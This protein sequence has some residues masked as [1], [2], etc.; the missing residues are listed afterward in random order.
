MHQDK[1]IELMQFV[2][3]QLIEKSGMKKEI[4]ESINKEFTVVLSTHAVTTGS[5][6][7][8]AAK[9]MGLELTP[10]QPTL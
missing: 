10:G 9:T 6:I 1:Q 2:M 8:E 5:A 3:K 4:E 7:I